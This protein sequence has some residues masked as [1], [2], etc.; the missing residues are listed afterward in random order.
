MQLETYLMSLLPKSYSAIDQVAAL[1]IINASLALGLAMLV[2][3]LYWRFTKSLETIKTIYIMLG[4]IFIL[5][6]CIWLEITGRISAGAWTLIILM[7]I[8]NFSSMAGY[9]I[10]SSASCG[11]ILP[12]LIAF[13]CVGSGAGYA[14]TLAGCIFV[15]AIP[16]VH[17]KGWANFGFP[18]QVSH[19]T[20]DA[21][22]LTLVYLL[23]A[24]ISGGWSASIKSIFS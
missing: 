21:P 10:S 7:V 6:I 13:F 18:Y 15:F 20:F 8:L 4:I 1:T 24:V 22:T 23:A 14:V 11:Y 17:S 5:A 9:G 16:I 19:I 3:V 2:L 12:I